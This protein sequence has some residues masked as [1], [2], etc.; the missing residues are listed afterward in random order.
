[1]QKLGLS[2]RSISF[3]QEHSK[4]SYNTFVSAILFGA[5]SDNGEVEV[6]R[7]MIRTVGIVRIYISSHDALIIT[8]VNDYSFNIVFSMI[9]A[10]DGRNVIR[11]IMYFLFML[12]PQSLCWCKHFERY[13]ISLLVV[14]DIRKDIF[15]SLRAFCCRA[16][17]CQLL[18]VCVCSYLLLNI[19][20]TFDYFYS[21]FSRHCLFFSWNNSILF[22]IVVCNEKL[23]FDAPFY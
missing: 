16:I 19:M 4:L 5:R 2:T 13:W 15:P 23:A 11:I 7:E 6:C 14:Q 21:R 8:K 17:H 1:M 20:N 3:N 10:K 18:I 12:H 22:F 9:G